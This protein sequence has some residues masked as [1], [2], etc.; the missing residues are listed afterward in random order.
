MKEEKNYSALIALALLIINAIIVFFGR[1]Y[2][3]QNF[4]PANTSFFENYYILTL[5]MCFIVA[6]LMFFGMAFWYFGKELIDETKSLINYIKNKRK[7]AC[8][9]KN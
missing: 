8:T 2:F 6:M 4:D 1:I 5:G 7:N 3:P 9:L